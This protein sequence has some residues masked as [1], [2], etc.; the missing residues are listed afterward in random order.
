MSDLIE[1]GLIQESPFP[2]Y[3]EIYHMIVGDSPTITAKCYLG[4]SVPSYGENDA[5]SEDFDADDDDEQMSK[6]QFRGTTICDPFAEQPYKMIVTSIEEQPVLAFTESELDQFPTRDSDP[7]GPGMT[8]QLVL[9]EVGHPGV[10]TA[11]GYIKFLRLWTKEGENGEILELFEAY[12]HIEAMFEYK[13]ALKRRM[14]SDAREIAF[15]AIRA[16]KDKNGREIGLSPEPEDSSH[17][18]Y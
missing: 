9:S 5:D 7:D 13:V 15:W 11:T 8:A 6:G 2:G 4:T 10:D 1:E 12:L 17:F 14:R 16:R 3:D 18:N